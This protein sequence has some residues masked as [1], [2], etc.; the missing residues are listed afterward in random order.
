MKEETKDI[1]R[2][3]MNEDL[4]PRRVLVELIV[5]LAT[6]VTGIV[7]NSINKDDSDV[8]SEIIDTV[9]KAMTIM[10]VMDNESLKVMLYEEERQHFN[11]IMTGIDEDSMEEILDDYR[12][13]EGDEAADMIK[14]HFY[15]QPN[16]L[17]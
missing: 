17:D 1:L 13:A 12:E 9:G 6:L 15:N 3:K 11:R 7:S 2:K 14:S 4:P 5:D 16:Q 10:R 8:Q